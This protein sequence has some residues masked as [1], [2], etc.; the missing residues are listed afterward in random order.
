M[1]PPLFQA[2]QP[3]FLSEDAKANPYSPSWE[4]TF[5]DI[6]GERELA[7]SFVS[8]KKINP[9]SPHRIPFHKVIIVSDEDLIPGRMFSLLFFDDADEDRVLNFFDDREIS[10]LN[11]WYDIREGGPCCVINTP[12]DVYRV[13]S[14]FVEEQFFPDE[15]SVENTNDL[16][17]LIEY[18]FLESVPNESINSNA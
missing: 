4:I 1:I 3:V 8:Y 11:C 9:D 6:E 10:L 14:A 5:F 2:L 12:L 15:D 16:L 7:S 13:V 18:T 17:S